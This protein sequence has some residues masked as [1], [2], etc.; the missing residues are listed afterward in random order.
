MHEGL[1]VIVVG[2][3]DGG[4][5][6]DLD[7]ELHLSLSR[8]VRLLDLVRL[9]KFDR[10]VV[11]IVL[12]R[13]G[14]L[15]DEMSTFVLLGVQLELVRKKI[16]HARRVVQL[17][18]EVAHLLRPEER[19]TTTNLCHVEPNEMAIQHEGVEEWP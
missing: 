17:H 18:T 12:R 15:E 19:K 13:L 8:D 1:H 2:L 14:E 7:L 3:V 6:L 4:V 16:D 5:V 11:E 9:A 10:N